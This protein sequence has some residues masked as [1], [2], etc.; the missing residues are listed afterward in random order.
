MELKQKYDVIVA[1]AG[2]AG[3]A[4]AVKAGRMGASVLLVEHYGFVGGMSTAGM[5]GPFMK[6]TVH[7]LPLVRGVFEDLENGMRRQ[8]GMIDNGFYAS[9]FRSSAY[10]L[11]QAA[12]VTVLLHG[13][14]ARAQREGNRLAALDVLVDGRE[15]TV[16]GDVFIDT[17][18]DAQLVFLGNFP[19]VKG[20]EKTG[21]LQALTLFFRMGGIDIQRATDY[22][23]ANKHDF[24]DWMTYDFDFSK[25]VSVAGYWSN[26]RRAIAEKRLPPEIEYIFFTTLPG[27]GEGSFNTSNVL[28]LDGS[29]SPD[30]TAAELTGRNQV[31]QLVQLIQQ[32]LPGFENS[33]L[34]E[35]A[36]QVGVR[37]TRRAVG[38]YAVTGADVRNM[39]KFPDPVAR[40][41]YG[42]DI[43]G[44]KG[45]DSVLEHVEEGEYYEV[46]LRALLVQ[47]A[48]N[49]LVAGRCI[50]STREG[51]SAIRIMPTS[52]A[53]GEACGALAAL[54]VR[55]NQL[56]RDIAYERLKAEIA[57]NLS[58]DY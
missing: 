38:D 56:L 31:N 28:G 27:S 37:E 13:E 17:T 58:L 23:Q 53:T 48:D 45:E 54:A 50:S 32:E 36:V 25:I 33:Y 41:S 42:I 52:S 5:V 30:L 22:V 21:L 20:D 14:I 9:S 15:V 7:G 40:S 47:Q 16:A 2:I 57:Y 43:H 49:L 8:N 11:L 55:N 24:F 34:V 10:E 18:G 46:P 3:I 35:T 26:V 6:H 29:S 1:G 12:G 39:H 4:A 51:H 44:Q 19:W